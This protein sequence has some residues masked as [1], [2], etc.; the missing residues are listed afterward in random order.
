MFVKA[1]ARVAVPGLNEVA[2]SAAN[3]NRK[4]TAR[5]EVIRCFPAA[6]GSQL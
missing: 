6:H 1:A 4:E 5:G 3:K 2:H